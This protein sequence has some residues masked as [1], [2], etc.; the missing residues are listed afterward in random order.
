M[1]VLAG[2]EDEY[3]DLQEVE[4]PRYNASQKDMVSLKE[5]S[6]QGSNNS[7]QECHWK[8]TPSVKSNQ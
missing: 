5:L 4:V 3:K 8:K 1:R 7:R 2:I 6:N